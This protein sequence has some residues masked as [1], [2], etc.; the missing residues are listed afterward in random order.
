M[1][2]NSFKSFKIILGFF[3][4]LVIIGFLLIQN[5]QTFLSVNQPIKSQ[6]L[7]IEGW[8][9][10]YA[11]KS[12]ADH[13]PSNRYDLIV[14]TGG[15]L[16]KGFFLSEYKTYANLAKATLTVISKRNDIIAVPA[17][18]SQKDRT[19]ISAFALKEWLKA[20]HI[21]YNKINIVTLDVHSRRTRFLFQ[22]ALGQNYSIGIIAIDNIYYNENKWWFSSLGFKTIVLETIA[23]FHTRIIFSFSDD[24]ST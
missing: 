21:K 1:R 8:L 12:A 11:L 10:D 5:V 15:P 23:Y 13:I 2:P 19:Y 22:K 7:V 20:N 18:L 24:V 3:L 17:R 14:T 9:P 6:I 4:R 16:K